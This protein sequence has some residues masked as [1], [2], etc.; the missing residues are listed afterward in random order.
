MSNLQRIE[1]HLQPAASL[2][3]DDWKI[4]FH[5]RNQFTSAVL[6][7]FAV[8]GSAVLIKS[9]AETPAKKPSAPIQPGQGRSIPAMSSSCRRT[10]ASGC[11]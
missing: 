4:L 10:T 9:T 8:L 7:L 11:I 5:M 3:F 1:L 2:D 6:A